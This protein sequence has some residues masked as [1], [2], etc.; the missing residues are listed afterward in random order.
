MGNEGGKRSR[1]AGRVLRFLTGIA[2]ILEGIRHLSGLTANLV[3]ATT[4]V[5]IG[6]VVFYT[7]LHLF[8]SR[9]FRGL[10]AWLGAVLAVA[11]VAVVFL[12][13]DAPGR[14][15]TLLFLGTSLLFTAVRADGGCEVMALP[16]VLFGKR[17]HLVCIAFSPVD[18]LEEKLAR[19]RSAV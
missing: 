19:R 7:L 17:T 14:L 15:G 13:S 12:V 6:E 10:N 11:P 18:W 8:V 5:V 4:G 2:L 1:A 3:L 9:Y 16:G